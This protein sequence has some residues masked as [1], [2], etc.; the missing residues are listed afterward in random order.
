MG[1]PMF[2]Q[3]MGKFSL[4]QIPTLN[5]RFPIANSF[6]ILIRPT[7]RRESLSYESF[8]GWFYML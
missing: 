2:E 8:G 1:L 6:I 4:N 7:I 3:T 5:H